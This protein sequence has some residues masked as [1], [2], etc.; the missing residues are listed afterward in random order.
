AVTI[1][2]RHCTPAFLL[3]FPPR[4]DAVPS[5]ASII[6]PNIFGLLLG[7]LVTTGPSTATIPSDDGPGR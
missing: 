2:G 6:G 5:W 1:W 3:G 4:I 7:V